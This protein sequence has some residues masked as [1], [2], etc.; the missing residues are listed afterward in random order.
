MIASGQGLDQDSRLPESLSFH[1]KYY[2]A[3]IVRDSVWAVT[4][5]QPSIYVPV[6]TEYKGLAFESDGSPEVTLCKSSKQFFLL[7]SCQYSTVAN[8]L[9]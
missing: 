8:E 1:C 7:A 4:E 2:K 3:W 6:M 9:G 5:A